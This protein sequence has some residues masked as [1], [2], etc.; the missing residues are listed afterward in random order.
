[1]DKSSLKY[2]ASESAFESTSD[3]KENVLLLRREGWKKP[4][5]QGSGGKCLLYVHVL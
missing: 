3:D 4:E 1:M 2:L 5:G